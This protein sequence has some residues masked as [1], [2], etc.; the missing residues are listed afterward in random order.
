[1]KKIFS[2]I[3]FLAIL[4]TCGCGKAA[5]PT[6]AITP[7]NTSTVHP[8]DTPKN[9]DW[10]TTTANAQ[11]TQPA[12]PPA[13]IV[14]PAVPTA[15]PSPPPS[16]MP[17]PIVTAQHNDMQFT[18]SPVIKGND[19]WV[20]AINNVNI[21]KSPDTNGDILALMK[22]G[23]CVKITTFYAQPYWHEVVLPNGENGYV[24]SWNVELLFNNHIWSHI[25]YNPTYEMEESWRK[26]L[27][28][29][30]FHDPRIFAL[31]EDDGKGQYLFDDFYDEM[32]LGRLQFNP[33]IR[34]F[35]YNGIVVDKNWTDIDSE[36]KI[37]GENLGFHSLVEYLYRR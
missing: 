6:V 13:G 5:S 1:M 15:T 16:A 7:E 22:K 3:I 31:V 2:I 24:Y 11:A 9:T 19:V 21:R 20:R 36:R 34:A 8:Q 30:C 23:G 27:D 4:L 14:T 18:T 17:T 25:N 33:E 29:T 37:I 10:P 12:T 32:V 28:T 35:L 26:T